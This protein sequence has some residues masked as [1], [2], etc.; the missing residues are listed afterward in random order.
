MGASMKRA[1]LA[2]VAGCSIGLV[3][4]FPGGPATAFAMD[5][6]PATVSRSGA[7]GTLMPTDVS[8]IREG[9]HARPDASLGFIPRMR[10]YVG[11]VPI[12]EVKLPSPGPVP[13]PKVKPPSPGPV[14]MPEVEA[15]RGLTP[16][17]E[18]MPPGA[19]APASP[20]M[21]AMPLGTPAK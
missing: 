14:P 15:R 9:R 18:P 7:V 10:G 21:G 11:P 12:P 5:A 4:Q 20:E 16:M 17:P 19:S 3:A 1:R 13:M 8:D 2:V 6:R